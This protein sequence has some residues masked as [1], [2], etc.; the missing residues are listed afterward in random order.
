M[1]IKIM[2]DSI[3]KQFESSIIFSLEI[4]ES[5]LWGDYL[6]FSIVFYI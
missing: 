5:I 1:D 6:S 4:L 3:Q 2:T